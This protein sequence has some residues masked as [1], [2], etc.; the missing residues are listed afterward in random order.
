MKKRIS[1]FNHLEVAAR[2]FGAFD[3]AQA[4]GSLTAREIG[5]RLES[6]LWVAAHRGVYVVAGSPPSWEQRAMLAQLCGGAKAVLSHLTAAHLHGFLQL[7][8]LLIDL[9]RPRA[10]TAEGIRVHR[11]EVDPV[12]INR[13]GPFRITAPART[14]IDLA[15]VL[16]FDR[17]EDCLEEALLR[18]S[19]DLSTL[20]ERAQRIGIRGRPGGA[21]IRRLL[22]LRDPHLVPTETKLET[23]LHRVLRAAEMP[24]PQRQVR[25]YDHGDFVTRID[26]AY[27]PEYI[28][29]PADSYEWHSRRRAWERDIDQRNRL[30]RM[31]W[32]LRPTTWTELKRSPDVFTADVSALL[33][34]T[35]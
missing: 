12:D 20:M 2:Q 15:G 6:G 1:D 17:L 21:A 14:L 16:D 9:I 10:L 35:K 4:R 23:L 31:G 7:R 11:G 5:M 24:I 27:L 33:R 3:R 28:G 25:I 19:L 8:P 13:V 30:L 18:S 29:I 32:R 22:D 34:E 26:F